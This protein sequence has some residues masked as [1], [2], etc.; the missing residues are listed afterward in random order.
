MA[1]P[2]HL[3]I[4]PDR[5]SPTAWRALYARAHH[6]ALHWQ[7]RPLSLAWRRVAGDPIAQ[8]VLD[9]EHADGLDIV[10]DATS[11]TV[12]EPV[13]FPRTLAIAPSPDARA[14]WV[15]LFRADTHALP[16][17]ALIIA[18][19]TLVVQAFPDAAQLSGAAPAH[20]RE[21]GPHALLELRACTAMA[22][23]PAATLD[24]VLHFARD[25]HTAIAR[26]DLRTFV[27]ALP[28]PQLR[29]DL[30]R[31]T[32][33]QWPLTEMAWA[34]LST[35][36]ADELTLLYAVAHIADPSFERSQIARALFENPV[37]RRWV[38]QPDSRTHTLPRSDRREI[39]VRCSIP[40]TP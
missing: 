12:G 31:A 24:A 38:A 14:P 15:T 17:H 30:A 21:P 27:R 35:A 39:A 33:P 23:L 18:L 40:S 1:T 19:A 6:L 37:L 10:G 13:H 7:P 3:A 34:S 25:L 2:L 11:R 4:L 26:T 8:Y 5:I 29:A 28:Q 22:T 36:S 16:Y 20:D 32:A 9:I